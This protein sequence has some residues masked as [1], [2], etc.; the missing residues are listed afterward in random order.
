MRR[1]GRLVLRLV[2]L[3]AVVLSLVLV[4]VV[5]MGAI[6][7]QRG[8]PQTSGTITVAGLPFSPGNVAAAI[9]TLTLNP[10]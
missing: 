4:A 2:K 7:T 10:R 8:L 3:V 5:V 1:G 9:Q 6:S